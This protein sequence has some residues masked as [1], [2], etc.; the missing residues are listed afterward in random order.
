MRSTKFYHFFVGFI[1][2][3]LFNNEVF[4]NEGQ[5]VVAGQHNGKYQNR[6]NPP[7]PSPP[8]SKSSTGGGSGGSMFLMQSQ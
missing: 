7:P 6:L 5:S 1:L 3:D 8:S 2:L 4:V